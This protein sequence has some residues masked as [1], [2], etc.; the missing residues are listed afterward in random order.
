[1]PQPVA[2]REQPP[3]VVAASRLNTTSVPVPSAYLQ[4]SVSTAVTA[5]SYTPTG[6][7]AVVDA[8][9]AKAEE[10]WRHEPVEE[11]L[12]HS[13]VKGIDAFINEDTEEARAKY[14]RPLLVIEGPLM[15]GMNV[16]GDLFGA[17]KMFLPQ[18]VKSA[19][20]MKKAVAYLTPFMEAEKAL[21]RR[22]NELRALA[23]QHTASGKVTLLAEGKGGF[24]GKDSKPIS[25][26]VPGIVGIKDVNRTDN[27]LELNIVSR[28]ATAAG[29]GPD[30]L[31]PG[32]RP[33]ETPACSRCR[34]PPY[35][36]SA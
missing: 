17:G 15:A 34:E 23:E 36:R 31:R 13:L 7:D 32:R 24:I 19:R 26:F 29:R 5:T 11:R 3:P 22:V 27:T 35:R 2:D 14:G 6:S 9:E 21:K 4:P 16:V 30:P 25:V 10:A 33:R 8:A 18:V 28:A 12:K 1:M 20:V